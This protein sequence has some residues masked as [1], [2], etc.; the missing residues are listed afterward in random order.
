MDLSTL[1]DKPFPK[2]KIL[3]LW[4]FS[5]F[6]LSYLLPLCHHYKLPSVFSR[7]RALNLQATCRNEPGG[8]AISN[9][10]PSDPPVVRKSHWWSKQGCVRGRGLQVSGTRAWEEDQGSGPAA[11]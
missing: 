10:N 8:L 9:R 4:L 3:G 1:S 5:L 7:N 6:P 11:C 2:H